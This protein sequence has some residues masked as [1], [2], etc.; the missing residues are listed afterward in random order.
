MKIFYELKK[1]FGFIGIKPNDK[2]NFNIKSLII[3]FL[4]TFCFVTMSW[5]ITFESESLITSANTLYGTLSL[6]LNAITF[7]SNVLKK[8]KIFELFKSFEEMIIS[9]RFLPFDL[10]LDLILI[11]NFVGSSNR[12]KMYEKI[13][14]QIERCTKALYI[15][16]VY[17]TLVTVFVIKSCISYLLYFT[18]KLGRDAFIPAF[19]MS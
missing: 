5:Y 8:S 15:A 6:A 16:A 10:I 11:Y 19:E 14:N 2:S 17:V 4:I 7:S 9:R 1:Q 3:L 12:R 18:T 13:D